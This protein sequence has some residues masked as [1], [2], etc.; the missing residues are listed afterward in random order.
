MMLMG[1]MAPVIIAFAAKEQGRRCAVA[2]QQAQTLMQVLVFAGK[3][4]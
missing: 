2:N 4:A 3:P 1:D